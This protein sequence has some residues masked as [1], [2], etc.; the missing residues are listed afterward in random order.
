MKVK[1]FVDIFVPVNFCNL[2]C[3]YCYVSQYEKKFKRHKN[4]KINFNYS[5]EH[6]KK[7]LTVERLGGLTHFNLCGAGETLLPVNLIDYVK[8]ILENGHSIM[9]VTNGVLT[10]RLK[11]YCALP[12]EL[13]NR[14]GFKFSFHYLELIRL[15]LLDQFF[16]NIKMVKDAGCSFSLEL[17]ATDEYEPY[18]EDIKKICL[19]KVG[20]LCHLSVPRN[21]PEKGIPLLSKHTKEEFYEIWKSFDSA[22]FEN[23]IKHWPHKRKEFCYAGLYTGLLA[24]ENGNFT[25]CYKQTNHAYN[26]FKDLSKPIVWCPVGKCAIEHCFNAHSFLAFGNIPGLDFCTYEQ[27]RDRVDKNGNHW[28]TKEMRE[29]LSSK[30]DEENG[31]LNKKEKLKYALLRLKIRSKRFA[32]RAI[33]KIK[34]MFKNGK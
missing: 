32:N 10:D 13:K 18:I 34:R 29:H 1:R 11:E 15:N 9:I 26:I 14:L 22:M 24:L 16:D 28:L 5:S 27:V 21:E 2:K 23:K 17:T 25:G 4:Y 19:E 8:V 33:Q 3:S 12:S 31:T 30:L 7:A 6:V 20:A